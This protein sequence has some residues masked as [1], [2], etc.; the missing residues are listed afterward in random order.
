MLTKITKIEREK[1]ELVE[2][3]CYTES[4]EVREIVAFVNSRRGKLTGT[5]DDMRYEIPVTNIFYIEAVDNKVFIYT[6]GNVYEAKQKLYELEEILKEKHF[7]RISKSMLLNLMKV[8]SIKPGLN[9]RFI[10][11]LN[12]DE[13]VIISRKYVPQLKEA[14]KGGIS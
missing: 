3:H 12:S 10:A 5:L 8:T 14:L 7:L 4:D 1:P 6:D 2:I 13:K 9:G 11:V